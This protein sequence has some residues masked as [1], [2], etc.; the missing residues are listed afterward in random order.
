MLNVTVT[1]LFGNNGSAT[2][3]TIAIIRS[4]IDTKGEDYAV[5]TFGRFF[6]DIFGFVPHYRVR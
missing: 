3:T 2:I 6:R 1:S 4:T 5:Y